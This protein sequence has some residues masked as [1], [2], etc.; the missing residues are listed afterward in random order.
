VTVEVPTF[1]KDVVYN[2]NL[3]IQEM[4][5]TSLNVSL[6]EY[7]RKKRTIP[8]QERQE[9]NGRYIYIYIYPPT[10]KAL[11]FGFEPELVIVYHK[12]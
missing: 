2:E 8:G 7:I 3:E 6:V 11:Q 9:T 1:K 4:Y 12:F 10:G 5:E